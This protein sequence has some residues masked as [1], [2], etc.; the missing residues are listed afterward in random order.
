MSGAV[1]KS[2]TAFAGSRRLARGGIVDV[3]LAVKAAEARG[4]APIVVFDDA[5]GTVIDFDLRG[6]AAEVAARL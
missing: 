3:A 6:S 4:E 2:C 1:P 5:S